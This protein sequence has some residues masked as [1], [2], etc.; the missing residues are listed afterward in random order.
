MHFDEINNIDMLPQ[1]EKNQTENE[2]EE[3]NLAF[4]SRQLKRAT[5]EFIANNKVKTNLTPQ[6]A[7][8]LKKLRK[9]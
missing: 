3:I 5:D 8:G 4:L 9:E 2:E 1:N 7:K 6:E